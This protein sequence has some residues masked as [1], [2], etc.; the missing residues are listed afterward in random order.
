M[1]SVIDVEVNLK[2][3][4]EELLNSEKWNE[5]WLNLPISESITK[6]YSEYKKNKNL[7]EGTNKIFINKNS[8]FNIS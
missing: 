2:I 5:G 4:K 7:K 8:I 1:V 6:G 3:S